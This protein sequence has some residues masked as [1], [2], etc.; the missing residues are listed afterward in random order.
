SILPKAKQAIDEGFLYCPE[1]SEYFLIEKNHLM[2]ETGE[3][4]PYLSEIFLG[5]ETNLNM[6][7]NLKIVKKGVEKTAKHYNEA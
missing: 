2:E 7:E 3:R 6:N 1:T 5:I 4:M